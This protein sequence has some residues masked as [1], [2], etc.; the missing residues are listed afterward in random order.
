MPRAAPFE[1]EKKKPV[2]AEGGRGGAGKAPVT[3]SRRITNSL[4]LFLEFSPQKNPAST[5]FLDMHVY[6]LDYLRSRVGVRP[7]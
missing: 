5:D 2:L 4:E 3:H 6:V 1:A 7:L